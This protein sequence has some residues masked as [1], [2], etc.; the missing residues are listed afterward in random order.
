MGNVFH[1]Q[2][3]SSSREYRYKFKKFCGQGASGSVGKYYDIVTDRYVAI[4]KV[5]LSDTEEWYQEKDMLQRLSDIHPAFLFYYNCFKVKNYLYESPLRG[6]ECDNVTFTSLTRLN[7]HREEMDDPT[8]SLIC[9]KATFIYIVMEYVKGKSLHEILK[10]NVIPEKFAKKI[11]YQIVEAMSI[12]H[13]Y[14]I[15]HRDLKPEHII[16]YKGK[17]KILDWGYAVFSNTTNLTPAGS[18]YY[19]SPEILS[20]NNPIFSTLNDVWALGV[21]LYFMLTGKRLFNERN[22]QDLFE[23]IK[24]LDYNLNDPRI[25]YK[26]E[27]LLR[28]I[29]VSHQIRISCK[30][31][32]KDDWLN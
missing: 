22:T 6:N 15:I 13:G 21:I 9:G 2:S 27:L 25:T 12:A 14:H 19:S 30:D 32:L 28:K 26:A 20:V 18:P 10:R 5:S 16:I 3:K 31:I 1:L 24:D 29:L 8:G 11:F 7:L 17:I 4:K 23:K